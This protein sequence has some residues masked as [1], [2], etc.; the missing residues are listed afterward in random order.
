M[1]SAL[2]DW[3]AGASALRVRGYEIHMGKRPLTG[4]AVR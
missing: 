3:L 4:A 1:A 2:P